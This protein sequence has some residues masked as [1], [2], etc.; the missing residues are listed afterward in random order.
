MIQ[1]RGA[2]KNKIIVKKIYVVNFQ[3]LDREIIVLE[4]EFHAIQNLTI[5]KSTHTDA[6]VHV[7]LHGTMTR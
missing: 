2:R 3:I 7:S 4:R 5:D 1:G 6:A